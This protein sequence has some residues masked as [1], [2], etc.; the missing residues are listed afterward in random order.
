VRARHRC[1]RRL[2]VL[3]V[4]ITGTVGLA[5]GERA[6]SGAGQPVAPPA[7]DVVALAL[8]TGV[9]VVLRNPSD[10][11]AAAL[12][13]SEVLFSRVGPVPSAAVWAYDLDSRETRSVLDVPVRPGLVAEV[14]SLLPF[15]NGE[16][17]AAVIGYR[18]TQGALIDYEVVIRDDRR[19][20]T[21]RLYTRSADS[22]DL[23]VAALDWTLRNEIFLHE[24][25]ARGLDRWRGEIVRLAMFPRIVLNL[26][27]RYGVRGLPSADPSGRQVAVVVGPDQVLGQP[28]HIELL[29]LETGER[30]TRFERFGARVVV[31]DGRPTMTATRL[32]WTDDGGVVFVDTDHGAA[33]SPMVTRLDASAT[34]GPVE[35]PVS[36]PGEAL[37]LLLGD[38]ETVL[39][40]YRRSSDRQFVVEATSPGVERPRELLVSPEP[41]TLLGVRP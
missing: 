36:E 25:R 27:E 13:G 35:Q 7:V 18:D 20:V 28:Y 30:W 22:Q 11:S 24:Y 17:V 33:V 23:R 15:I 10:F 1:V 8:D 41:V 16:A 9:L 29:D 5:T 4:L 37:D 26:S 32:R 19:A 38:G 3:A 14:S 40:V 21:E 12:M 2:L 6:R 34:E 31:F 39:V